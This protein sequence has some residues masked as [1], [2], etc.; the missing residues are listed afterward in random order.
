MREKQK[1]HPRPRDRER[2][3]KKNNFG[4]CSVFDSGG[5]G[6]SEW[7]GRLAAGSRSGGFGELLP[8]SFQCSRLDA[9]PLMI[10]RPPACLLLLLVRTPAL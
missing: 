4:S 3:R 10:S 8:S 6:G 9:F 2:E 7:A 5:S 1:R